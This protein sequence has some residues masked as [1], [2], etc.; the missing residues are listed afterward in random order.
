M[1]LRI[2]FAT[3]HDAETLHRFI[4]ELAV[5]EREP[6]AVEVTPAR[7]REQLEQSQPPFE[8]LLAEDGSVACGM[9]LFF[10]NYSTWRGRRGLYLEDLYVPDSHRGTGVGVALMA[11][12]ARL[13]RD[14]DCA[15]M[16]WSV[17]DWNE[18]AI[19]FYRR[20]GAK[21]VTGWST[22]WL[23]DDSLE[24][25][26]AQGMAVQSAGAALTTQSS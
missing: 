21:Q 11:A 24:H 25:L 13:A 16:Q 5:Y 6:D 15:R 3:P 7:L 22:Y 2:R 10:H 20:L 17:L 1:P 9:A 14:R 26:A 18:V 23:T 4:C 8:C 19:A 12:L